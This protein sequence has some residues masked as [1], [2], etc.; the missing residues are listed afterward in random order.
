MKRR[1]CKG[2]TAMARVHLQRLGPHVRIAVSFWTQKQLKKYLADFCIFSA[3]LTIFPYNLHYINHD[4]KMI[5]L[6]D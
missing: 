1:T 3:S 4:D 5:S 2:Y 6:L